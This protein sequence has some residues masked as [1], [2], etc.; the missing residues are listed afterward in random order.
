MATEKS[1]K[2]R[3]ISHSPTDG[4]SPLSDVFLINTSNSIA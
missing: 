1:E 3:A 2:L 4:Y